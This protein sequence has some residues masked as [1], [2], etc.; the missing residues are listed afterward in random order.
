MTNDATAISTS[1]LRRSPRRQK[2]LGGD[3]RIEHSTLSTQC[4]FGKCGETEKANVCYEWMNRGPGSLGEDGSYKFATLD[5]S[6]LQCDGK[7]FTKSEFVRP[8]AVGATYEGPS[9]TAPFTIE[10]STHCAYYY[11]SSSTT[12]DKLKPGMTTQR[13][14]PTDDWTFLK[15]VNF[16]TGFPTSYAE[17]EEEYVDVPHK[18]YTVPMNGCSIVA[19]WETDHWKVVHLA[20]RGIDL[21]QGS[22]DSVGVVFPQVKEN[23]SD[24]EMRVFWLWGRVKDNEDLVI[25]AGAIEGENDKIHTNHLGL[26]PTF[27]S[28]QAAGRGTGAITEFS[29]CQKITFKHP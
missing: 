12:L 16:D 18:F 26:G 24:G 11:R 14:V 15:E 13:T 20:S 10:D 8:V 7:P 17:V 2:V 22:D 6:A 4:P 28:V 3:G 5:A 23:L 9:S 29:S 1:L 25:Y 27:R 19:T 21:A